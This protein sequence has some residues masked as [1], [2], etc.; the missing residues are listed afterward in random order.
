MEQRSRAIWR[1]AAAL[2]EAQWGART[3]SAADKRATP[4]PALK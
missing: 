4:T 3:A 2:D 1:P